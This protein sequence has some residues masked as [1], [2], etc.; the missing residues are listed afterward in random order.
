MHDRRRARRPRPRSICVNDLMSA[1]AQK[2][3][4]LADVN[5]SERSSRCGPRRPRRPQRRH[6]LRGDRVRRRSI[7]PGDRDR[8]ARSS[9]TAAPPS[10]RPGGYAKKPWPLLAPR[11][12]CETSRRRIVGGSNVSSHSSRAC[13]RRAEHDVE[14]DLIGA[15]QRRRR[16]PRTGQHAEVDLPHRADAVLKDETALDERRQREPLA[17]LGRIELTIGAHRSPFRS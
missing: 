10:P 6:H 12:P 1:P 5:T 13:S 8:V 3:A 17:Q 4:G 2:R 11:R 7:E 15:H 9:L 14:A 16:E